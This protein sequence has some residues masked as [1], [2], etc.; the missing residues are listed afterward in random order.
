MIYIYRC[1]GVGCSFAT[2]N[3]YLF[4]LHKVSPHNWPLGSDMANFSRAKAE[5]QRVKYGVYNSTDIRQKKK[6]SVGE[7]CQ[8][9]L[10]KFGTQKYTQRCEEEEMGPLPDSRIVYKKGIH[11]TQLFGKKSYT[12]VRQ[13]KTFGEVHPDSLNYLNTSLIH[14]GILV[15]VQGTNHMF[16]K[17]AN[18]GGKGSKMGIPTHPISNSPQV[19]DKVPSNKTTLYSTTITPY[20]RNS[21]VGRPL[22]P[23]HFIYKWPMQK[24]SKME[25]SNC[26][27][28]ECCQK[29]EEDRSRSKALHKEYITVHRTINPLHSKGNPCRPKSG[30]SKPKGK[31]GGL[32]LG[33]PRPINHEVP[34]KRYPRG[35]LKSSNVKSCLKRTESRTIFSSMQVTTPNSSPSANEV[36]ITNPFHLY[37]AAK[38]SVNHTKICTRG[39]W[40]YLG[41]LKGGSPLPENGSIGQKPQEKKGVDHIEKTAGEFPIFGDHGAPITCITINK[42]NV[43]TAGRDGVIKIWQ[44]NTNNIGKGHHQAS[45]YGHSKPINSMSCDLSQPRLITTSENCEVKI[46]DIQHGITLSS[47]PIQL[48][49]PATCVGISS[50]GQIVTCSAGTYLYTW[51]IRSNQ[52]ISNNV[53][54]AVTTACFTD[55]GLVAAGDTDGLVMTWDPRTIDVIEFGFH[56]TTITNLHSQGGLLV[57]SEEGKTVRL[58]DLTAT[59]QLRSWDQKSTVHKVI[60]SPNTQKI[61]AGMEGMLA[62]INVEDVTGHVAVKE[63]EGWN[64][65]PL[66]MYA[67]VDNNLLKLGTYNDTRAFYRQIEM[68]P[69]S[70]GYQNKISNEEEVQ[71]NLLEKPQSDKI[72][73][74]KENNIGISFNEELVSEGDEVWD[75]DSTQKQ[76]ED[77]NEKYLVSGKVF[78]SE[79]DVYVFMKTYTSHV[80]AAFTCSSNGIKQVIFLF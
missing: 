32:A 53:Y 79:K 76:K 26:I 16:L 75:D 9:W 39:K 1:E 20:K 67:C 77:T 8:K 17:V 25:K 46:F 28:P 45:I 43:F 11:F 10:Q 69:S 61:F 48:T 44:E 58:W 5:G 72:S 50:S 63:L 65:P 57:S 21:P 73:K 27:C 24:S 6:V 78:A 37:V 51:D 62:M 30:G 31:C 60:I 29:V 41:G 7:L 18:N 36:N 71:H 70:A 13:D 34:C 14:S 56:D 23:N 3:A 66:D 35:T 38:M 12:K 74:S 68:Y 55:N 42:N 40:P 54:S 4:G 22:N 19:V 59:R 2:E 49:T 80:R 15:N 64:N 33:L 47:L 52:V